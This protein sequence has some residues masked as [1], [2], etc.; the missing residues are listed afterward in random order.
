[1]IGTLFRRLR[2]I[3]STVMKKEKISLDGENAIVEIDESLAA[4]VKYHRG[5]DLLRKQVLIYL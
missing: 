5:K 4:R 3:V 1:M 2:N